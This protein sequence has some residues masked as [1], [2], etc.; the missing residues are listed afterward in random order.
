MGAKD[1]RRAKSRAWLERQNKDPFV[2]K[3]RKQGYRARAAYK[4]EEIDKKYRLIRP[5]HTIVDLGAAPGSWC[6]Y[7]AKTLKE[8]GQIVAVDLLEMPEVKG[9]QFIQADFTLPET[10]EQ[11]CDL[12]EK[13]QVDLVLSDMA[14]NITGIALQDQGRYERLLESVLQFCADTLRP[15]GNLLTKFFEGE[16]AQQLRKL[17]K[18]QFRTVKAIKPEASRAQSREQYLLARDRI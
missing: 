9:V 1:R 8:S 6:Q 17:Y 4:L 2:K 10:I 11:I 12:L 16:S 13:Q 5:G 15:G 3:A 7:A 14:P 18:Q